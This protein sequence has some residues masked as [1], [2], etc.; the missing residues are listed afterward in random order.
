MP[1]Q[2]GCLSV[3]LCASHDPHLAPCAS[4]SN[5]QVHQKTRKKEPG[6]RRTSA[7]LFELR[8]VRLRTTTST[9][10]A[11]AISCISLIKVAGGRGGT[12]ALTMPDE[13][14]V[15][16]DLSLLSAEVNKRPNKTRVE[17]IEKKLLCQNDL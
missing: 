10:A 14:V 13:R 6:Q 9:T 4:L 2:T 7:S 3:C 1:L 8:T 5:P 15:R 11:G 16:G 12:C 17:A